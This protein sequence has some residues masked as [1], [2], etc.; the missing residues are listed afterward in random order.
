MEIPN[1]AVLA[2]S[3]KKYRM[4]Y[5]DTGFSNIR[6]SVGFCYARQ[7]KRSSAID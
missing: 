1:T 4:S 5:V 7:Q 6:S 2:K 3:F